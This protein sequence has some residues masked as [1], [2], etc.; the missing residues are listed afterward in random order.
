MSLKFKLLAFL[1]V[2]SIL[3]AV[4]L[5]ALEFQWF[6]NTFDVENLILCSL[7]A[8]LVLGTILAWRSKNGDDIASKMRHWAT[9]LILPMLLMPLI[10]SLANRLLSLHPVEEKTFGFWEEKPFASSRFG[11]LKGEKIEADGYY[12]FILK[13]GKIER[14]ESKKRQFPEVKRG[15]MVTIPVQKGLFGFEVVQWE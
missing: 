4:V 1:A 11:M 9:F 6:K 7:L 12:I 13:D 15:G 3:G 5:Y 2:M 10:G 8:G 14:L